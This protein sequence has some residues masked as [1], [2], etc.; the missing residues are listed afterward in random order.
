MIGWFFFHFDLSHISIYM[1]LV[2]FEVIFTLRFIRSNLMRIVR[3]FWHMY[4]R[5][6][7]SYLKSY[8]WGVYKG[9]I[10]RPHLSG[11]TA[12]AGTVVVVIVELF[13]LLNPYIHIIRLRQ[14]APSVPQ[15]MSSTQQFFLTDSQVCQVSL[16]FF[17]V[18]FWHCDVP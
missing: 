2:N 6:L 13:F 11:L 7:K 14:H 12:Y 3:Q 18:F 9:N 8:L 1:M 16:V 5:Y 15:W 10:N 4:E 17:G